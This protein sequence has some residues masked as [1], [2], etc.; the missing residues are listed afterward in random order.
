MASI[1][2]LKVFPFSSCAMTGRLGRSGNVFCTGAYQHD[3]P[4]ESLVRPDRK[5]GWYQRVC[6]GYSEW[7]E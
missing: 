3:S 6:S 5:L 7:L 2:E 4:Q 1:A